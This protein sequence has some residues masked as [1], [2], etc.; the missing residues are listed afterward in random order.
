MSLD[1]LRILSFVLTENF[2]QSNSVFFFPWTSSSLRW[3]LKSR[4]QSG[5]S[6]EDDR[7]FIS[8]RGFLFNDDEQADQVT[9][10]ACQ[11]LDLICSVSQFEHILLYS[12]TNANVSMKKI[13]IF[14]DRIS[15]F[16]SSFT[17]FVERSNRFFFFLVEKSMEMMDF[18]L[19][20]MNDFSR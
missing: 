10:D 9:S 17:T 8:A 5:N 19:M 12:R 15:H 13:L 20:K 14:D 6:V 3:W 11:R 2:L 16:S 4:F 1:Q 18:R 7:S